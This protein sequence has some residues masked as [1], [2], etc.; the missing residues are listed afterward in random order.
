M[1]GGG[2]IRGRQLHFSIVLMVWLLF[3]PSAWPQ[4]SDSQEG[5]TVGNYNIRQ[6]A[7]LGYRV[8]TERG[9]GNVFD[10]IVDEHT[11]LRLL[12]ESFEVHC[13]NYSG[14]FF[15]SLSL[16]I[17]G[18]RGGPNSVVCLRASKNR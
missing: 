13:L 7:A 3:S 2:K 18:L 15:C 17:L 10:T 6:S 14:W 8:L 16:S 9:N 12:D 11:G 4:Q 1:M 5:T